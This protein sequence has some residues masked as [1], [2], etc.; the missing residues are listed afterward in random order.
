VVDGDYWVIT[1]VFWA[2]ERFAP[3]LK[4]EFHSPSA[5]TIKRQ[6]DLPRVPASSEYLSA[7]V[8]PCVRH[9]SSPCQPPA[10]R[11]KPSLNKA[12]TD[13]RARRLS[14]FPL[15]LFTTSVESVHLLH[16]NPN[17]ALRSVRGV[18]P[19]CDGLLRSR[20]S[21]A[22]FI[23]QPCSG[24]TLQGFDLWC[25]AVPSHPQPLPSCRSRRHPPAETVKH[26]QPPS[27]ATEVAPEKAVSSSGRCSL[28][29]V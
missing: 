6:H 27:P 11:K 9:R 14:E 16:G 18:P 19:T 13:S 20:T 10:S 1:E 29:Q 2:P 17:P 26:C 12:C 21:R 15:S 3:G 7:R 23:P 4:T 8:L 25:R 22:Y 5:S 28:H 24:F